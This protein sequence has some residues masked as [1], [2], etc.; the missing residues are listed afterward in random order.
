MNIAATASSAPHDADRQDEARDPTLAWPEH[1]TAPSPA[2]WSFWRT[3]GIRGAGFPAHIVERLGCPQLTAAADERLAAEAAVTQQWDD[4][5]HVLSQEIAAMLSAHGVTAPGDKPVSALPAR[6]ADLRRAARLLAARQAGDAL[7][8]VLATSDL[9]RL[10]AVLARRD[11][12]RASFEAAHARA[13]SSNADMLAELARDDRFRE[14]VAWQ[15]HEAVATAIDPIARGATMP[16]AKRRQREELIANYAQRY[17]V[18]N[19][20]IGFFGPIAWGTIEDGAP[21]FHAVAGEGPL[22]DRRIY[23]EDWPIAVLAAGLAEDERLT[24]WLTPRLMPFLALVDEGL[25]FPGGATLPLSAEDRE[26]LRACD[27]VRRVAEIVQRLLANPFSAFD[28]PRDVFKTLRGLRDAGRIDL[29]FP[30]SSSDARPERALRAELARIAPPAL[31]DEALDRLQ[32]LETARA[33]IEAARGRPDELCAALREMEQVFTSITGA[34]ARRRHGEAY[35]GRALVYEDCRRDLEVTLGDGL[36]KQLQPSLDLVL[37]SCRWFTHAVAV[38]YVEA[39]DALWAELAVGTA[40]VVDLPTFWLRAQSLFFG[41]ELPFADIED[42]VARRWRSILPASDGLS[43]IALASETLHRPAADLFRVNPGQEL[44][45]QAYYQSPDL[46]LLQGAAPGEVPGVSLEPVAVLGEVHIGGNT[47]MTN[48]FV[49][50]HPDPW[51]LIDARLHDLGGAGVMPKLSGVGS[52]RPIRT[53]W[54][55]DPRRGIEVLFSTG[56]RPTEARTALPIGDLELTREHGKTI[57][58][59]RGGAW[60]C[61][62]LDLFGDFIVLAATSRFRLATREGH[63]PRITVDR[64]VWQR[65]TWRVEIQAWWPLETDSEADAYLALHAAARS[66]GLPERIFVKVPWENKPFFVDFASP[67][68][69]RALLK[70]LRGAQRNGVKPGTTI[71]CSEMLPCFEQLWLRDVTG[72]T[73]TSELRMVAVH[74]DDVRAAAAGADA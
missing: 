13:L 36:L 11:A 37:M 6:L 73:F 48:G 70:Q 71:V 59:Q 55:D 74:R 54:I 24:P 49:G 20:T 2:G 17:G 22:A 35:G 31:R 52:R 63:Q 39:L 53:Q 61:G 28:E 51:V 45:Q 32:A 40:G 64:V 5:G 25:R 62:L 23:F 19:D 29:A 34:P 67:V 42:E 69:V 15:N 46:L 3:F 38:R 47:L 50:Q 12:A 57:V 56:A 10:T 18:K 27:G 44:W 14:A 7:H 72:A 1:L 16:G 26:L 4:A 43:R 58:R 65:E 8:H 41:D 9:D 66:L 68:H 21:A 30:I 33:A 60:R